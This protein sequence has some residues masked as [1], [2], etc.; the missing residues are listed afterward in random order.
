MGRKQ[1]GFTTEKGYHESDGT[2]LDF[3][4]EGEVLKCG[5]YKISQ[6]EVL[7]SN[8]EGAA[9]VPVSLNAGDIV[10]VL[11]DNG[12]YT[13]KYNGNSLLKTVIDVS[14]ISYLGSDL[15]TPEITIDQMYIEINSS[16]TLISGIYNHTTQLQLHRNQ[17]ENV[18]LKTDVDIVGSI[19]IYEV[20]RIIE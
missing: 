18:T 20:V 5:D 16:G 19:S 8:K 11:T 2:A 4:K 7:W 9:E 1:I 17:G 14:K 13:I 12:Y 15:V 6:I 10:R 3:T